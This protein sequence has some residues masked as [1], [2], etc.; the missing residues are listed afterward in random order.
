MIDVA[1]MD[2]TALGKL[3]RDLERDVLAGVETTFAGEPIMQ[4]WR[5][6]TT[7]QVRR[8]QRRTFRE[9]PLE[10]LIRLRDEST[11]DHGLDAGHCVQAVW[12]E[13]LGLLREDVVN[14]IANR[15]RAAVGGEA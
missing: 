2:H 4:V 8:S 5:V 3:V 13:R 15:S 7:E 12:R 9:M 14:E 1:N 10:N 11:Q 6:A